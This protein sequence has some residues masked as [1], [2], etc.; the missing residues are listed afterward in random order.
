VSEIAA[1]VRAFMARELRIQDAASL[2][3]DVALIKRGIL[4]SI[5]LMQVVDFLEKSYGIAVEDTDI[6]P[7]NLGSFDNIE[8]FVKRKTAERPASR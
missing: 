1:A 3:S 4:D 5:E 2:A 6:L 7:E 8:A